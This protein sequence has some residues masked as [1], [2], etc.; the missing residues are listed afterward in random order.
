MTTQQQ[1]TTTETVPGFGE[2]GFQ[3]AHHADDDELAALEAELAKEASGTSD[4]PSE[5]E[6]TASETEPEDHVEHHAQEQ[7]LAEGE[8]P[9]KSASHMVPKA[10]L[11]EVLR[12]NAEMAERIARLEGAVGAIAMGKP[13]GTT[14]AEE[15]AREPTPEER[16]EAIRADI[17]KLAEQYESGEI[18]TREWARENTRLQET[19]L[20]LRA[21]TTSRAAQS[22]AYLEEQTG[23]LVREFPV[24]TT[25][26]S[27]DVEAIVPLARREAQK[28]GIDI[29][30][31]LK[32]RRH[33]AA[34]AQSYYGQNQAPGGKPQGQG[35]PSQPAAGNGQAK[36]NMARNAPPN[37]NQHAVAY[38]GQSA[39]APSDDRVMQMR[40]DDLLALPPDVLAKIA[41]GQSAAR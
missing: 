39:G 28:Q 4:A 18:S 35:Q 31:D 21:A 5:V 14:P 2:A 27:D 40:D 37:L 25:I 10:R 38:S 1:E 3:P 22:D 12:K 41:N 30:T 17:D 29:S 16:I 36:L 20:D 33:I 8:P 13:A 23:N 19:L 15:P 26:T 6:S 11:D 24:L 32:L 34:F 7:P 9:Q